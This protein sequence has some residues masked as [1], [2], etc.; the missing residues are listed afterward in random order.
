MQFYPAYQPLPKTVRAKLDGK[1][2]EVPIA[3]E[4]KLVH[5]ADVAE[6]DF[7]KPPKIR[8]NVWRGLKPLLKEAGYK[9]DSLD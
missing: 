7:A 4:E 1:P 6:T 8:E 5:W 9:A 3:V 2:L